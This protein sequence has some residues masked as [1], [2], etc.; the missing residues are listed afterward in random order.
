[1]PG[2]ASGARREATP[3]VN[4]DIACISKQQGRRAAPASRNAMRKNRGPGRAVLT[5]AELA[6]IFDEQD[7]R[8]ALSAPSR[9]ALTRLFEQIDADPVQVGCLVCRPDPSEFDPAVLAGRIPK[10]R[11]EALASRAS[12][13]TSEEIARWQIIRMARANEGGPG[14]YAVYGWQVADDR[15]RVRILVTLHVD[16]GEFEGVAGLFYSAEDA[17]TS[18]SRFGNFAWRR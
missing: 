3:L 12:E 13:P 10:P 18:L 2:Q 6:A 1:V 17:A 16:E 4:R 14:M 7:S 11:L 8:G 9:A 15:G 5:P